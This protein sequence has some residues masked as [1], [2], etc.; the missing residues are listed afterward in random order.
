M[1][2]IRQLNHQYEESDITKKQSTIGFGLTFGGKIILF[3]KDD[4]RFQ[5]PGENG[6][7]RYASLNFV[8]SAA[9]K[10]DNT[11]NPITF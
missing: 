6:L 8:N 11:L 10:S 3:E 1:R 2:L 4:I 5:F 7:G 9:I